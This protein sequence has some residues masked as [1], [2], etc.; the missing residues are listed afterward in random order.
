MLHQA[1]MAA[2]CW[3]LL[4]A[5]LGAPV[6]HAAWEDLKTI[7]IL[8]FEL[9]DDT[10]DTASEEAQH[11]RLVLISD[12]LRREFE[13]HRLYRV[14]DN[15]P[16]AE[17]IRRYRAGQSLYNCNGCELDIAAKL[18]ADRVSTAWVQKVSNLILN[19]NIEIKSVANGEV[20]LKKSV[21]IRGNTDQSWSRGVSYLVRDM[22]EKGQGGR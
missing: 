11:R 13:E 17:T 12:Q 5:L 10:G 16:A 3:L 6:A 4:A 18:N 20:V 21:D 15:A 1:I 2:C 14:L 8:N 7:V 9:I 19:L 22:V